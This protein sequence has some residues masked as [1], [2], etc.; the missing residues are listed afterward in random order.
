MKTSI[1][2]DIIQLSK[3]SLEVVN[4]LI[5]SGLETCELVSLFYYGFDEAG[6]AYNNANVS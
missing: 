3:S 6:E 5:R 4:V 2:E 1:N